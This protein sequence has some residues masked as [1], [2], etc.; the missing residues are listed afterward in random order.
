MLIVDD[1]EISVSTYCMIP[2]MCVCVFIV[3]D[4]TKAVLDAQFRRF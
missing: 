3:C 1:R 4:V 2:W